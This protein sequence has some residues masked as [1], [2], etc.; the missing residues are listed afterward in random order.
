MKEITKL[1]GRFRRRCKSHQDWEDLQQTT[2]LV[3]LKYK[4]SFDPEKSSLN[5]WCNNFL[6]KKM[7]THL[8]SAPSRNQARNIPTEDAYFDLNSTTQLNLDM[9][10]KIKSL[11]KDEINAINV[12]NGSLAHH[13]RGPFARKIKQIKSKLEDI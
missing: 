4:K 12:Y 6:F 1:A 9:R 10:R 7:L 5:T 3:Y 11:T 8:D 2:Y 13:R